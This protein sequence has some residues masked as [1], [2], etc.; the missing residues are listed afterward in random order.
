MGKIEIF[1]IKLAKNQ[2]IYIA[3][4]IV[5]GNLHINIS[6]RL[7]INKLNLSLTACGRVHWS[8]NNTV[9]D[10]H[11]KKSTSRMVTVHHQSNEQYLSLNMLLLSKQSNI[12]CYLEVGRQN[13]SFQFQLPPNLPSS[14]EHFNANIRYSLVAFIDIPWAFNKYC[15]LNITVLSTVNLN[16]TPQLKQSVTTKDATTM[17]CLC[18]KSDPIVVTLSLA[19]T[20][21][22][23]GEKLAFNSIID[24][25]SSYVIKQIIFSLEQDIYCETRQKNR[26]FN[27]TVTQIVFDKIVSK[28]SCEEWCNALVKI[29]P[30]CPSSSINTGKIINISYNAKLKVVPAGAH[31]SFE[32]K[33]PIVMGTIPFSE[34]NVLN[35]TFGVSE[36]ENK[37]NPVLSEVINGENFTN[38]NEN[39]VPQYPILCD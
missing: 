30:V 12:D 32:I 31:L 37:I 7:K 17:C 4:E 16:L 34:A 8:E 11:G 36:F 2:P 9:S 29:P 28:N 23:S 20:G 18:C 35:S 6:E 5:T 1:E 39:F 15:I 25:K 26:I 14:F 21:F 33:I 13:F 19:K 10:N 22:V 24:N 38:I 27:R 3:G